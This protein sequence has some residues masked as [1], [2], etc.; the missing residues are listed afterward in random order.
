[1]IFSTLIALIASATLRIHHV[2]VPVIQDADVPVAEVTA[3]EGMVPPLKVSLR[4]LR[5]KALQD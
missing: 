2:Q 5:R 3:P 4:G 1:M